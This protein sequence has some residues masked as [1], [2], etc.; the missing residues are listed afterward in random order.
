MKT[1]ANIVLGILGALF[2]LPFQSANAQILKKLGKAAERAAERTVERR[3]ER[4]TE[5]K[6]DEVL[7]SIFEPGKKGNSPNTGNTPEPNDKNLPTDKPN[8][9]QTGRDGTVENGSN[10]P[11]R[12]EIYSKFDFVP[13]DKLLFFDDFSDDF[14]GDFPSKWN[15][16]G[17][18]EIITVND[19]P[20]KWFELKSGYTVYYLPNLPG[21]LPDEYTIEFDV[22]ATGL[23]KKTSSAS[24]LMFIL[25]DNNTFKVGNN[26]AR[27]S[28]PFCQYSPIGFRLR[29][30]I[31]NETTINNV[32]RADIREE[33]LNR[34]IFPLP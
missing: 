30:R 28:I 9:G 27:A 18:G 22:L 29:N 2:L 17:T 14:I 20:Q 19:N 10:D 11:E 32:V 13:G 8:T 7:D 16:N 15:T 24:Q 6:T 12:L 1:P 4:E 3:V 25:E 23:D 5:K 26:Y 31:N 34:P 21:D 33:V